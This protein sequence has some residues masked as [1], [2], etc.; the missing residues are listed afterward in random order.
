[1]IHF[2][3]TKPVITNT[4][5]KQYAP[6][7]HRLSLS[8]PFRPEYYT[9]KFLRIRTFDFNYK[10]NYQAPCN[11][12]EIDRDLDAAMIAEDNANKANFI[13]LNP[14]IKDLQVDIGPPQLPADFWDAI[15]TTLDNPTEQS[16]RQTGRILE[17]VRPV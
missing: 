15:S 14:T 3:P 8:G 1:M 2:P 10:C 7:V 17:G 6:F 16:W 4:R 5:L 9:I 11:K 13:R 12:Y